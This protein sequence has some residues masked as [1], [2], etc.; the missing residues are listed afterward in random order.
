MCI[1]TESIAELTKALIEFQS[2]APSIAKTNQGYKDRYRYADLADIWALIQPLLT[3]SKLAVIQTT[4]ECQEGITI[5]TTLAHE[6]GEWI[7]GEL[8]MTPSVTLEGGAVHV[9]ID[10]QSVGSAI[11]YARRYALGAILGLVMDEDDDGIKASGSRYGNKTGQQSKD[12]SPQYVP[13][14]EV[15]QIFEAYKKLLGNQQHATNA[16]AKVIGGKKKSTEYT[17][18]DI[19]K[20]DA[21]FKQRKQ[22][23]AGKKK[24]DDEIAESKGIGPDG[25]QSEPQGLPF[26]SDENG[27][28]N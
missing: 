18:E 20:L 21:D 13:Q 26:D 16:M 6:S 14:G 28:I 22:E 3:E 5:V 11:T 23:I 12:K 7:R 8:H 17:Q 19:K 27:G 2:K 24:S 15:V 10:P 1:Q 4:K 25:P 9:A